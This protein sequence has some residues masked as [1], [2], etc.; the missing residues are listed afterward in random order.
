M[1]QQSMKTI[2]ELDPIFILLPERYDPRKKQAVLK[3][4]Q[5][6]R[7][8]TVSRETVSIRNA[9][10]KYKYLIFDTGD[11]S[12]GLLFTKRKPVNFNAIGSTKKIIRPGDII[13]SRLRPYLKQVAWIDNGLLNRSSHLML[14]CSTEFYVLRSTSTESIAFL[15]PYLLSNDIQQILNASQEGGHHPRFNQT[16]LESLRIPDYIEEAR[17]DIS[18]KIE[19]SVESAR[20]SEQ[21]INACITRINKRGK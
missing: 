1:A 2:F 17:E 21:T 15:V 8:I 7:F 10:K 5:I 3:G 6:T 16:T 4:T 11:A 20:F 13:I 12:N 19:A 9:D 18:R 14:V